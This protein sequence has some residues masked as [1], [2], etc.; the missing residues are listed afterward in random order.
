[1]KFHFAEQTLFSEPTWKMNITLT[2]FDLKGTE[3]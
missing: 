2:L 1:M 3:L